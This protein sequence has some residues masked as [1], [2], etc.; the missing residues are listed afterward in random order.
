MDKDAGQVTPYGLYGLTANKGWMSVGVDQDT[1][2]FEVG[3]LRR[4]WRSMGLA[5]YPG[6]SYLLITADGGGSNS[7]RS[8]LWKLALQEWA[9]AQGMSLAFCHFPPAT[10]KWNSIEHRMFSYVTQN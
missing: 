10:S 6:A 3:C 4:W 2:E 1:A 9:D 7:S 5:A 8:L